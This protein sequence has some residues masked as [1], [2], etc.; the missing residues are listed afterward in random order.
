MYSLFDHFKLGRSLVTG[1]LIGRRG[2]ARARWNTLQWGQRVQWLLW[3]LGWVPSYSLL[4]FSFHLGAPFSS[5]HPSPS[6]G[7]AG[8]M[9][10]WLHP[11]WLYIYRLLLWLRPLYSSELSFPVHLLLLGRTVH[12]EWNSDCLSTEVPRSPWTCYAFHCFRGPLQDYMLQTCF[13]YPTWLHTCMGA[14]KKGRLLLC[15]FALAVLKEFFTC[16]TE[17]NFFTCLYYLGVTYACIEEQ[18]F[19]SSK[20]W[21]AFPV[22]PVLKTFLVPSRDL[23]CF[24]HPASGFIQG[25]N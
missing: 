13:F 16:L 11:T 25:L 5:F 18:W 22:P 4:F 14:K 8:S 19:P 15:L 10:A 20:I 21:K 9:L 12:M 1:V 7:S 23:L 6:S 17:C 2:Q 3:P 24:A